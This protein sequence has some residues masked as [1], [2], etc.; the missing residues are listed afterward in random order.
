M[1][2]YTSPKYICPLHVQRVKYHLCHS[3]ENGL[4][5]THLPPAPPTSVGLFNLSNHFAMSRRLTLNE[6][7]ILDIMRHSSRQPQSVSVKMRQCD[8]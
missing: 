5:T 6:E 1:Y 7:R 8:E 3:K 4:E 2:T